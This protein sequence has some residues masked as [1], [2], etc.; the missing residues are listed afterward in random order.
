MLTG[1]GQPIPNEFRLPPAFRVNVARA[2]DQEIFDGIVRLAVTIF[3]V[4]IA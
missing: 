1:S 4:P 3:R 2:T